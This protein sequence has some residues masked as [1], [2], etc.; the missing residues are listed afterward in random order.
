VAHR[1][2]P[3]IP[4]AQ[5]IVQPYKI[6]YIGIVLHEFAL[7]KAI[8]KIRSCCLANFFKDLQIVPAPM[9]VK[10]F[11]IKLGCHYLA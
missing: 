3:G 10:L 4:P 2:T 8:A 5:F 7:I 11:K 6:L 1:E 9:K